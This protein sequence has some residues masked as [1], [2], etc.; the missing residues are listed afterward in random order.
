LNVGLSNFNVS[1]GHVTLVV[2]TDSSLTTDL[3]CEID[4]AATNGSIYYEY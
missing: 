3:T 1:S 2:D 4:W